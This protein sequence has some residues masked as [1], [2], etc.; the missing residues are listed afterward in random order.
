LVGFTLMTPAG[1]TT[2]AVLAACAIALRRPMEAVAPV[3]RRHRALTLVVGATT[4]AVF[5]TMILAPTVAGQR[6]LE[7]MRQLLVRAKSPADLDA[8]CAAAEAV[9][10]AD[11]LDAEASRVAARDLLNLMALPEFAVVDSD[12]GGVWLRRVRDIVDEALRRDPRSPEGLRLAA[13]VDLQIAENYYFRAER[14]PYEA[15]LRQAVELLEQAVALDPNSM[16]LR[17]KA[18]RTAYRLWTETQDDVDRLLAI[19]H[20]QAALAVNDSRPPGEV[21][22]LRPYE[23]A[24]VRGLLAELEKSSEVRMQN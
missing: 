24:E 22:R 19:K 6:R 4:A 2:F 9:V 15:A 23:A 21:R 8:V 17:I 20:L 5:G 11:P 13:D 3:R 10:K 14:E 16:H 7:T 18:G 1:A 12:E